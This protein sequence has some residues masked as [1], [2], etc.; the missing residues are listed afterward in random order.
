MKKIFLFLILITTTHLT[1]PS[2]DND[3]IITEQPH[4]CSL[5]T[6]A[7]VTAPVSLP[8]ACAVGAIKGIFTG[9][10]AF[11]QTLYQKSEEQRKRKNTSDCSCLPYCITGCFTIVSLPQQ[12]L[13]GAC[14]E[15]IRTP[16][17]ILSF[18]RGQDDQT[19]SYKES[20]EEIVTQNKCCGF[21]ITH[22][23]KK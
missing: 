1:H 23:Y 3:K 5:E 19:N 6:A 21:P 10:I 8:L 16:A 13:C 11:A 18:A 12:M 7:C 15:S 22:L 9:P 2:E 17:Q 4:Y 14:Y 20:L